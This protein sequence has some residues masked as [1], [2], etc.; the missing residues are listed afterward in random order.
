MSEF[1]TALDNLALLP[2]ILLGVFGCAIFLLD[3]FSFP[4]VRTKHRLAWVVVAAEAVVSLTLYSQYAHLQRTGESAI[5][6][7]HGMLSIDGFALFFNAMFVVAA[8][9]TAMVSPR[10]LDEEGEQ[11]G[12]Y[13]GLILLAQ[14]GMFFLAATT[15]LVTLFVGLELMALTFYVLVGFLARDRR[16]NE[17]A[18]KYFVLGSFS[19]AFLAYG[20]SMLYGLAGSTRMADIVTAVS[21]RPMGDP[22]LLAAVAG[23]LVG[24]LFKL[25]VAPFHMWVPDIYEGAPTPVTA[26][27]SVA[28]KAAAVAML[29]RLF[30]G[31]FAASRELW[32]PM[33]AVAALLTIA[34]G[35]LAALGQTSVKRLL[36]YSSVGHAGYI[37]LGL[38]AGNET[39]IKGAILYAFIY[40]FMNL[41]AFLVLIALHRRGVRGESIEELVGLSRS[42]GPAA[43]A[44]MIFLISLAGIPP[45]AG[46]LAK[47]Y[48]F[49]ALIQTQHYTLAVV[50]VVFVA[51]AIYYYFRVI[52]AMFVQEPEE[53]PILRMGYGLRVAFAASVAGTLGIGVFAE[54]FVRL[55]GMSLL[56]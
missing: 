28:S 11:R 37:L 39:G 23:T 52:R 26:Y 31:P 1:Y 42:N 40:T 34:V 47:Y 7:F 14:C 16:S 35:N 6:A 9:L 56:R 54:P 49:L 21:A 51:V 32:E 3:I 24:V 46:F 48:I 15:E 5:N 45:T 27:L 43:I 38:V 53:L 17:A 19:S 29:L 36:A 8:V 12:E 50:A 25:G 20:F 2:A 10:Y 55:V 30:E 22:L 13:Y 44:M 4:A 18:M 33:L 41:G